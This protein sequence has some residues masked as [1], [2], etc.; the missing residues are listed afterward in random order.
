MQRERQERLWKCYFMQ[1]YDVMERR[2]KEEVD[3]EELPFTI[4]RAYIGR[5]DERYVM[6]VVC[7]TR[8]RMI[9]RTLS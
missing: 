4:H 2:L 7:V 8:D 9:S 5:L 3:H 1:C 6:V